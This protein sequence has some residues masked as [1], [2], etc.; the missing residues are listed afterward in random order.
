[1]TRVKKS[2]LFV[3]L[4][5][6]CV[7]GSPASA[8]TP[9]EFYMWNFNE[10]QGTT[11]TDDSG[12]MAADLGFPNI[13][14]TVVQED[15]PSG[16]PGDRSIIPGGLTVYDRV[17]PV[18][19]LVQGPVTF[20]AWVK[21]DAA[22]TG[23]Q[24]ILRIGNSLKAGF[25]GNNILFT[26]L[27]IVDVNSQIP[28]PIDGE[29][30]HIAYVWDPGVEVVFYLDGEEVAVVAETRA[31]RAF[32]NSYMSIGSDH[33][34]GSSLR[35]GIDR[36]RVHNAVLQAD[37]LDSDAANPKPN[38]NETRVAYNFNETGAPFQNST[39][40]SRPAIG[41]G[42]AL[43]PTFSSDTPTGDAGD[44]SLQ[45]DGD[46]RVRYDDNGIFLLD[47]IAE[48][49]TFESWVKFNSAEQIA[50]RPIMFAYGVGGQGGY[51]FSLRPAALGADPE[52]VS[53]SP[54][55][56]ASDRSVRPNSGLNAYEIGSN[57]FTDL[58]QGPVTIEAWVKTGSLAGFT[59]IA[60]I[61]NSIKVGFRD[62]NPVF[63]LLGVA[64]VFANNTTLPSTDSWHH[65]AYAWDPGVGIT[66]YVD[67]QESEFVSATGAARAF[68]FDQ[69]S[70]GA[71]HTGT[72]PFP[73]LIDRLQIHHDLLDAGQLDS[74]AATPK[75]TLPETVVS[76]SFDEAAM[77]YQNA[78]SSTLAADDI[79]NRLTVT[80]FGILDAHSNAEVPDDGQWH[81]IAAVFDWDEFE[82]RF[83][84]DGQ[85][86]DR[87]PYFQDINPAPNNQAFLYMGSESSGNYYVGKL[88]R[89]KITRDILAPNE[90]DW[91]EPT[92]IS[93]WSLY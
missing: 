51:S 46:D 56:Q 88:D 52:S 75:A 35:A 21:P 62:S 93:E 9:G 42:P 81:H 22:L 13:Q 77:P 66:F 24:D 72:S 27:G 23:N 14:P 6:L 80:T 53:D 28:I 3:A 91:F 26:L 85:L 63:T 60:R 39:A 58:Q 92:S 29:W 7:Q 17:D 12:Q 89:V 67:G 10:G 11:V 44:F 32:Q 69:L 87:Y 1:M 5:L 18:L 37:D 38:L 2:Y 41:L 16:Q 68:N 30:H 31:A 20:E 45:F 49:F 61:G 82:F 71:S 90:L 74:V 78:T 54:S 47:I 36:L 79:A 19:N 86:A 8:Q 70:I 64:D 4:A 65:I 48:P 73:G 59:D 55:G 84:V 50:A 43:V 57:P 40:A 76:Y 34:G 25:T 83:Y 15:S 33:F